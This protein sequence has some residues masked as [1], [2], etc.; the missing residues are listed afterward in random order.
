MFY[1]IDDKLC[2]M[3]KVALGMDF[4]QGAKLVMDLNGPSVTTDIS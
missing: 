1:I 4:G 2:Q 3:K